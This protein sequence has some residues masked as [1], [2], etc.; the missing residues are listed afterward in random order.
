MRIVYCISY[1]GGRR[2]IITGEISEAD[3]TESTLLDYIRF[4]SSQQPS[5]SA[6]TINDRVASADCAIRN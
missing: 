4:Q 6:T 3:L 1:A 5:P 2:F